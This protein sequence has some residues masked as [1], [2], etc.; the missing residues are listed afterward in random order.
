VLK[1]EAKERYSSSFPG[2]KTGRRPA[3]NTSTVIELNL[4][5]A[6]VRNNLFRDTCNVTYLQYG[7]QSR[8]SRQ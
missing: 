7:A 3:N 1:D 6:A 4:L 5:A 8:Q 2:R